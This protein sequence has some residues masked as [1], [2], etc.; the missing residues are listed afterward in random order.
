[1]SPVCFRCDSSEGCIHYLK[2]VCYHLEISIIFVFL[3]DVSKPSLVELPN[4]VLTGVY[5]LTASTQ[6]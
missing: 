1:M 3:T 4:H 5:R 6:L 2:Y